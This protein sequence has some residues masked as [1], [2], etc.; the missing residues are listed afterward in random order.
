MA[1]ERI[2]SDQL[3]ELEPAAAGLSALHVPE[4]GIVNFRKVCEQMARSF[5]HGAD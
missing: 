2:H 1:F 3:R 5:A 4:T